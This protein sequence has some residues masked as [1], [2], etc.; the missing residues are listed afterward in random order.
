MFPKSKQLFHVMKIKFLGALHR[1]SI[2]KLLAVVKFTKVFNIIAVL[3]TKC[4]LTYF[5]LAHFAEG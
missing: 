5:M 4:D 1:V 3:H 2:Y